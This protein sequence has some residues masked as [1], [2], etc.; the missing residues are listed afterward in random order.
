ME[1]PDDRNA[2]VIHV[3]GLV[4]STTEELQSLQGEAEATF[5]P[6]AT[7]RQAKQ[8]GVSGGG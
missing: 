1:Q 3:Q 8:A 4:A 2:A 7:L 6:Q 5:G